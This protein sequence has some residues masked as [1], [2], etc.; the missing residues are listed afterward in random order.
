MTTSVEVINRST[1]LLRIPEQD[2]LQVRV[3]LGGA[4]GPLVTIDASGHIHV[5]PPMGPGDPELRKAITQVLQGVQTL[6][7]LANQ[8][9]A[10]AA[11]AG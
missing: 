9:G 8:A 1:V 3:I 6:G 4:D 11:A 7:R 2:G 10:Q 5:L